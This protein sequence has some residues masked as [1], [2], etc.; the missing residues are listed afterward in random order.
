MKNANSRENSLTGETFVNEAGTRID[1]SKLT[2]SQQALYR[3]Y[4]MI[5]YDI[6]AGHQYALKD[7]IKK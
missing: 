5:T 4:Q 7:G 1:Y 6:N 3:D 2:Q